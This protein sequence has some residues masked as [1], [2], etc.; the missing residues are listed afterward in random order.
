MPDISQDLQDILNARYGE[1]VRG[2]IHDAIEDI[3]EVCEGNVSTVQ[4]I[5]DGAEGFAETSEA[6]AKGTVNGTAVESGDVGYEDNSL[7]YKTQ[8]ETQ[9]TLSESYSQGGTGTRTGEDTDNSK[10]YKEQAEY[11]YNQAQ[12]IASQLS[13]VLK[14]QGTVAFA[15]LPSLASAD[16]GDMYNI[17]DE[18]TTTADFVEGAGHVIPLGSNVYK[19]VNNLWDVLAGSPVTGV[20]GDSEVNYRSGNVNITKANIGLGNVRNVDVGDTSTLTTTSTQIVGAINE[21][22]AEI[23]NT[24][25]SSIGDGTVTGSISAVNSTLSNVTPSS[26]GVHFKFGVTSDQSG[27]SVTFDTPFPDANY[28]VLLTVYNSNAA[29]LWSCAVTSKTSTGFTFR[30]AYSFD[31]VTWI[32]YFKDIQW[33]AIR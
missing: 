26:N 5:V 2:S 12:S 13:G 7:Y 23:G 21:L 24:N 17:S 31:G 29:L 1:E 3:N 11:W 27:Q 8:A 25:I 15:N 20:K 30:T 10:Y 18:F 22:D 4:G 32:D 28:N 16:A 19:T 9:A 6:Y 33:V 14:P